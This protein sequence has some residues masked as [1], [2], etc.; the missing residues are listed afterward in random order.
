MSVLSEAEA[1]RRDGES[2]WDAARR[3]LIRDALEVGGGGKA[4]AVILGISE[5][6][7]CFWRRRFGMGQGQPNEFIPQKEDPCSTQSS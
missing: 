2:A 7:L 3:L 6:K 5:R 4:A 1:G